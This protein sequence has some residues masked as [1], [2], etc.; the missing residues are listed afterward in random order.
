MQYIKSSLVSYDKEQKKY[1]QI[2]F[3]YNSF[4]NI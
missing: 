2:H 4:T 1:S 3:T